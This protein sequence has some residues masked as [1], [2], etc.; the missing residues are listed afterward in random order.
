MALREGGAMRVELIDVE[1]HLLREIA[2]PGM[3]RADVALTY[4]FGIRQG[5]VDWPLV[6]RAIVERWSV[7]GLQWIKTKA[8]GYA[9]RTEE[10]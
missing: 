1:G 2:D 4:A 5:G 7:S 9:E 10:R 8:W 6:N 3:K